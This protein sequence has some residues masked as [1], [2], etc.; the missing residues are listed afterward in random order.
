[1]LTYNHEKFIAQAIEGVMMQQTNFPFELVIGEDCSTD[2]TRRIC[3][4]YKEKYPET[5]QLLLHE[6]NVGAKRNGQMVID[7]C[8]GKY[9][10]ICEGDDYWTDP[11][12]LQKQVDFLETH[13]DYSACAHQCTVIY[14][15]MNRKPEPFTKK[16]KDPVLLKDLLNGHI[17]HLN[18]L[19]V[20]HELIQMADNES[21]DIVS[22][23]KY[24]YFV[25]AANGFIKFMPE[26]MSVY[27][28]NHTG[29]STWI[30]PAMMEADLQMATLL[31][32]AYPWFPKNHCLSLIHK[33]ILY[34][35]HVSFFTYMK[36]YCLYA[37]YSFSTFPRNLVPLLRFT[38][39][40]NAKFLF[41]HLFPH[42]R[43]KKL[44]PWR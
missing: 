13:S 24:L 25:C 26:A 43:W 22:T 9:I 41:L 18:T 20:K 44:Q 16:T 39:L 1:M 14:D 28:I 5:I 35:H 4:Q 8:M 37:W 15:Y 19:M 40:T 17:C 32:N 11:C 31:V 29:I 27:R 42:V 23:D 36:H 2:D 34:A 10:A 30:N 21:A 7:A 12:K 33:T 3:L 38:F 6:K